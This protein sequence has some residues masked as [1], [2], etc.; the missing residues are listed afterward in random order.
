MPS[1]V[2]IH[3]QHTDIMY[4]ADKLRIDVHTVS[5]QQQIDL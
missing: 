3:N 5:Q 1:Q 4:Y 2:M